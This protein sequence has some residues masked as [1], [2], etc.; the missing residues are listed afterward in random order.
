MKRFTKAEKSLPCR[1]FFAPLELTRAR[2]GMP[3]LKSSS[4]ILQLSFS[5]SSSVHL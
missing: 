4:R 2:P 1:D 3:V 5:N